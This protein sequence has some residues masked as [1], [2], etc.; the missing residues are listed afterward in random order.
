MDS[1]L[2]R[3]ECN[4]HLS[5]CGGNYGIFFKVKT[6]LVFLLYHSNGT[7]IYS[8]YLDS[9]GEVDVGLQKGRRQTL[10]MKRYDELRR[11]WLSGGVGTLVARKTEASMDPGGWDTT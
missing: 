11:V 5:T 4:L 10:Y 2:Q 3:G 6:N 9:H 8:P 7:F 1:T